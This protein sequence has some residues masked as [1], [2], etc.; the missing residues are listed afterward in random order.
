MLDSKQGKMFISILNKPYK[1]IKIDKLIKKEDNKSE[2]LVNLSKVLKKTK[3]H[4]QKQFRP[5]NFDLNIFEERWTE[6]YR[7]KKTINEQWYQGLDQEIT[8][9][10]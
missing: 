4:Y 8:E 3:N 7:P 1:K 6:Y 2:L 10:E 9:K 5:R